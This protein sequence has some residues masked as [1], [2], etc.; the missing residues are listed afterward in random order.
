MVKFTN[1][2]RKFHGNWFRRQL[3][4]A[5]LYLALV[6]EI[7]LIVLLNFQAYE[8]RRFRFYTLQPLK[9]APALKF[10]KKS[11]ADWF[12]MHKTID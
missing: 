12:K 1:I 4:H 8:P 3:T 5:E 9:C 6:H 11:I 10:E 2:C 7:T